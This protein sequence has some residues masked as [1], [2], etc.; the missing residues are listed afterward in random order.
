[1]RPTG[2]MLEKTDDQLLARSAAAGDIAA[3]ERL[4][5][6]HYDRIHR[7]AWRFAGG[8][9]DSEDLA[10][11]ICLSLGR[12]I[13]TFRGDAQFSTW[14]YKVVLNAARD[15]H[16]R[17]RSRETATSGFA[18]DETLRRAGDASRAEEAAWLKTTLAGL[19]AELRETAVLVLDE[20]LTHAQAAEVLGV[21][22]STVSWRLMEL[23]K[24]LK[25]RAREEGLRT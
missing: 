6:R 4:I 7:L 5:A 13:R 12:K 3:F 21:A 9:P 8:P 17:T 20:D 19:K 15:H 14:L 11:D 1:M 24:Q 2:D 16:R 23:R 25:A 10:Q 18:E 22:E